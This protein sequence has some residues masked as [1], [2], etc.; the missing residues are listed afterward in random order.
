MGAFRF[1]EWWDK[2]WGWV[3]FPLLI[4][5][6][7]WLMIEAGDNDEK[8]RAMIAALPTMEMGEQIATGTYGALQLREFDYKNKRC[9]YA[10][11]GIHQA[12]LTCWNKE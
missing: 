2:N 4:A 12:G 5:G 11:S 1:A 7:I 9:L 3:F 10:T 8:K 6:L